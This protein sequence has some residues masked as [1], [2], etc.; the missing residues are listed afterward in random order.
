LEATENQ[1]LNINTAN[2]PN[3]GRNMNSASDLPTQPEVRKSTLIEFPGVNRTPVPEWRKE[4]SERVREV[5]ER[6]ARE[7]AREALEIEQKR[8][9]D[10]VLPPQLE[11]LPPADVPAMNP[12]VAAAL[13]RIER[14]HQTTVSETRQTRN[15]LATAVAYA[16]AR[17]ESEQEV[18]APVLAPLLAVQPE[19]EAQHSFEAEATPHIEKSH[20]TVV[21][22]LDEAQ[23]EL[24]Q[25]EAAPI[26]KRLIVD[27][28][29]DPALNYLDTISRNV[30]VDEIETRRPAA[31]RR[32]VCALLDLV[33]CGLL[34]APIAFAV[35][36]TGTDLQDPRAIQVL[37]GCLVVITFIY[38]TLTTALTGRTWAMRLLSLRV[39]DT[40]TGLIPTGSQSVGRSFLYL[41]SLALAGL[42][43]LFALVSREGYT[44][45]DR[46]TRTAV[47]GT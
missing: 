22:A 18:L 12:L 31:F 17:E 30:R 45:H 42:G 35:R 13:K 11:L 43:I 15:N 14:A 2:D 36:M 37:V 38:L 21:P 4:L 39:I 3:H 7:A 23:P 27:D 40:K 20:L 26:P 46:F 6:R 25:P 47:I 9:E 29:N 34:C 19:S 32:L 10:S 44:V 24:K 28:P 33:V 5:Q 1:A 8:I 41:I 16:P